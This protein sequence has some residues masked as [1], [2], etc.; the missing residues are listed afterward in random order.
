MERFP[1]MSGLQHTDEDENEIK[2]SLTNLSI[3]S[4]VIIFRGS[5]LE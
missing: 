1:E 3:M 2:G 4:S 5:N